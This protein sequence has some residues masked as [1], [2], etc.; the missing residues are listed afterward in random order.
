[1][2]A[3]LHHFHAPLN[4]KSEQ[5]KCLFL[6]S[7]LRFFCCIFYIRFPSPL[8]KVSDQA[9]INNRE[10]KKK[11]RYISLRCCKRTE[12]AKTKL[13]FCWPLR[14][15]EWFVS[16]SLHSHY[17]ITTSRDTHTLLL[18]QE[19]E[20]PLQALHEINLERGKVMNAVTFS[21]VTSPH[22]HCIGEAFKSYV[23]F[24]TKITLQ[25]ES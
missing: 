15:R 24:W 13:S 23:S 25:A 3:I 16:L 19:P 7:F 6:F 11:K 8:C 5:W 4:W 2:V 12:G 10:K 18:Q 21:G 1:M 14:I 9:E 17:S 22:T 20:Q